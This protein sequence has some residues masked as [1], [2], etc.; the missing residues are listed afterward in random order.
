MSEVEIL[1]WEHQSGDDDA[2]HV[3]KTNYALYVE[4]LKKDCPFTSLANVD[5]V[6]GFPRDYLCFVFLVLSLGGCGGFHLVPFAGD[7]HTCSWLSINT[8][9]KLLPSDHQ[10]LIVSSPLWQARV[11]D[12]FSWCTLS[13]N[14]LCSLLSLPRSPRTPH[15]E[16]CSALHAPQYKQPFK[17]VDQLELMGTRTRH[18]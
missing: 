1:I 15:L 11:N 17:N 12:I 7:R 4:G 2:V 10:R 14:F 5:P 9:Q 16:E 18:C 8:L 13:S 6:K 3:L